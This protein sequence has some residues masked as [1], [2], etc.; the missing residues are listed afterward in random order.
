MARPK[1]TLPDADAVRALVDGEG[2]LAVRV[3]PGARIEALEIAEGRLVAKVRAKPQ[4]GKANDAVRALLASALDLAPSRLELLRG[5]TS[6]E[7]QF[8]V[9]V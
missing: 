6:R 9:D 4:D 8:R 7:K 3:T 2:R 1:A 5:A